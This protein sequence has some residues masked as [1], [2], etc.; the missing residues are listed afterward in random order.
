[1]VSD[2]VPFRGYPR[3]RYGITSFCRNRLEDPVL[4]LPI[5]ISWSSQPYTTLQ[6]TVGNRL[7]GRVHC[8]ENNRGTTTLH[9][10]E[11]HHRIYGTVL[12]CDAPFWLGGKGRWF[13]YRTE[14]TVM[15]RGY[16]L[17]QLGKTAQLKRNVPF[18]Q[19]GYIHRQTL[20]ERR[21]CL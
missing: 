12:H 19:K 17:I 8:E 5:L 18:C 14:L 1:M 16:K 7:K 9:I 2:I 6:G 11:K 15:E 21:E 13:F 20:A 3:W 4:P 10:V